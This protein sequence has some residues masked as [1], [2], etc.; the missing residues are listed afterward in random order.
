L[1]ALK[2]TRYFADFVLPLLFVSF[3]KEI[4]YIL[5]GPFRKLASSSKATI[6][7]SLDYIKSALGRKPAKLGNITGAEKT[8]RGVSLKPYIAISYLFVFA[9][10]ILVNSKQLSSLR[11]FEDALCPIPEGSLVLTDFSLQYKIVYLRPDLH[12]IPSCEMGF[13]SAGV[14]KEYID[15]HN[16]GIVTPLSQKTGAKYLLECKDMYIDPQERR[17]LELVNEK[18]DLKIWE[19]LDQI[20][21]KGNISRFQNSSFAL[22]N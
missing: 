7:S 5:P 22:V 8:N 11:D 2:Y 17:F 10:L 13:A 14:L 16:E 1:P 3:G 4:L 9:L 18:D 20:K 21:K 19:I 12:V 15:F 6:Q